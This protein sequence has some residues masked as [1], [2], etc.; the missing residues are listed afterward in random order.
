MHVIRRM[1][2]CIDAKTYTSYTWGTIPYQ[3]REIVYINRRGEAT[4][5]ERGD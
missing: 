1:H 4:L 2:L 5:D 3:G